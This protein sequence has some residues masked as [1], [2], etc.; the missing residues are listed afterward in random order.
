MYLEIQEVARLIYQ[1]RT[2]LVNIK[3]HVAS[4]LTNEHKK[5]NKTNLLNA[6]EDFFDA[7]IAG[8]QSDIL[9]G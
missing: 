8:N 9:A 6:F 1:Y 5:M 3:Q 4:L 7:A 2:S